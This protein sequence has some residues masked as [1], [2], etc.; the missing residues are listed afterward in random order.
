MQYIMSENSPI[1]LYLKGY[2]R[3]RVKN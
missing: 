3:L 2:K 1:P